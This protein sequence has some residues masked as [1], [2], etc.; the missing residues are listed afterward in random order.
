VSGSLS[1][2]LQA[3]DST[4]GASAEYR[5]NAGVASLLIKF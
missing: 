1:Y 4:L 5:E 2:R 3:K